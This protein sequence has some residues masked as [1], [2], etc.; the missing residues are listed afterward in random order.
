M[1]VEKGERMFANYVCDVL[2]IGAG[3][4]GATAAIQVAKAGH[5]VMIADRKLIIGEPVACAG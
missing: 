5:K 1:K 3:P 2:I 4:A